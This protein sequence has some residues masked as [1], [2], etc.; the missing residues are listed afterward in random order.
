MK[1]L[2][3]SGGSGKRLW[4]LSNDVR[5]KQFLKILLDSN[6]QPESMLQRVWRQL[7]QTDLREQ[8]LISTNSRQAEM[9][10]NQLGVSVPLILEPEPRDTFPAIALATVYLHD[11]QGADPNEV[12]V[13]MPVDPYVEDPFFEEVRQLAGMLYKTGA[14][15]GLI[16]VA[17]TYA[18]TKYGYILPRKVD[19]EVQRRAFQAVASFKEKPTEAQAKELIETGALWNC[20]V[21]AFRIGYLL[22]LLRTQGYP[23][24]YDL[25]V[26]VYRELPKTSFDYEVVEKAKNVFVFP[27]SGK[28]KDLGTWNTL[29]EEMQEAVIG[30]GVQWDDCSNTHII[31]ELNLPIT[32]VGLSDLVVAASPDGILVIDKKESHRIKNFIQEREQRTMFEERRW[33]WYRVIDFQK[34]NEQT[35]LLTKKLH[36]HANKNISYQYHLQRS[37]VW[38]IIAGEGEFVLNDCLRQVGPGDVL[39]IPVGARHGIKA[40]SDLDIIEVQMGT[41]LDEADIVRVEMSW[42]ALKERLGQNGEKGGMT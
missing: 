19:A 17:P 2:L 42:E 30:P 33:G 41:R 9:I 24:Q 11:V 21:F 18:S 7:G 25:F 28:W 38:V 16:G 8:V 12:M 10:G 40:C 34:P 6:G 39:K 32:A 22:E 35:E 31:N 26:K 15:I 27:Y 1:L 14:D 4:P 37:E 36:L 5:S 29:T 20:G 13:A 3:L 23:L